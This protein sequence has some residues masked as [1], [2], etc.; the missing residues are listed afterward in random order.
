MEPAHS[1]PCLLPRLLGPQGPGL[2]FLTPVP[3]LLLPTV[4]GG[5]GV[6]SRTR[7]QDISELV[8]DAVVPIPECHN[9]ASMGELLT[10]PNLGA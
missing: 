4:P 1:F 7:A 2:F 8:I 10:Y 9:G 3:Q 6:G 5:D